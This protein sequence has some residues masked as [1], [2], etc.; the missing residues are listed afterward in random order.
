ML[1][2]KDIKFMKETRN[3]VIEKRRRPIILTLEGDKIRNPLTGVWENG[4]A[5]QEEVLSVVTDRTSR[6][7][8]E[9]RIKDQAAIIEG[10]I[11]FS[12]S[13][14]ELTRV[15]LDTV[16]GVENI[17]Y[18]DHNGVRYSVGSSDP[19]GIGEYNRF[20]FVGKRVN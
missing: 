7:A 8:S 9:K 16:Q 6:V 19:K 20:E 2:D 15:G 18:V 13:V 17:R 11:W 12:I 1:T 4:T 14:D 10:D 5:R 3:E